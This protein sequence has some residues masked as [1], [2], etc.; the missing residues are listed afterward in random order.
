MISFSRITAFLLITVASF[1][2]SL[3]SADSLP[4]VQVEKE[5]SGVSSQQKVP[6]P[7]DLKIFEMP[8]AV[9]LNNNQWQGVD[10]LG[11][12][13]NRITVDVEI[14]Q[15]QKIPEI[16]A[17]D[18]LVS[19]ARK[20]LNSGDIVRQLNPAE[21]PPIPLLHILL[22]VYPIDKD[23]FVIFGNC[24]LFEHVD[25][26]RKN[27]IPSGYW[28]A[29]TWESL[30]VSLS[31]APQLAENLREVVDKLVNGFIERYHMYNPKKS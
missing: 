3:I 5:S 27:F 31:S 23:R 20:L 26:L 1:S 19:Y 24:R 16:P 21:G 15:S 11:H 12:L 28:Q 10:Y 30:D 25:V 13:S 6:F 7:T 9:I 17:K 14:I 29:I 8:G 18:I 22:V 4:L 2:V